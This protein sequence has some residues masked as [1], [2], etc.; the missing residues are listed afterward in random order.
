MITKR[1]K[2]ETLHSLMFLK[3]FT[4]HENIFSSSFSLISFFFLDN[5]NANLL[6]VNFD[7][8]P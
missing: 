6:F 8:E 7:K 5:Y 3:K 4:I 2:R 1:T